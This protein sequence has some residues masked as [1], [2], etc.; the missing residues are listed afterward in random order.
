MPSTIVSSI[1]MTFHEEFW[2]ENLNWADEKIK[3]Q[4]V[5]THDGIIKKIC[6]LAG[7]STPDLPRT[8]WISFMI[9]SRIYIKTRHGPIVHKSSSRWR[10]R[11]TREWYSIISGTMGMFNVNFITFEYSCLGVRS[12]GIGDCWKFNIYM[13]IGTERKLSGWETASKESFLVCLNKWT[14]DPSTI[15]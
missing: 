11:I 2:S 8:H 1:S 13:L 14:L 4:I 9:L 12:I 5:S 3:L 6:S 10:E 7:W 15:L